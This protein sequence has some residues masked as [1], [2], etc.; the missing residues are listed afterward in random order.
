R[1]LKPL[2]Q[3]AAQGPALNCLA[4]PDAQVRREAVGVIGWLKQDDNLPALIEQ[5]RADSDP[6]VRR[7]ATGALVYARP[8]LVGPALVET[9]QDPHWQ[10]RMEAAVS[11]GKL[12]YADGLQ[13]LVSATQDSWWQVREK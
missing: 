8:E 3:A 5:A 1:A 11:I 10:V 7:A 13:A 9:L 6:D 12:D 2:R 4:H